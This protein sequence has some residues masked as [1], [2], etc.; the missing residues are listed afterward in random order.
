MSPIARS[1]S[2]AAVLATLVAA[3]VGVIG[4]DATTLVAAPTRPT[5]A[6]PTVLDRHP[7]GPNGG[8]Q[9]RVLRWSGHTWLVYPN[10]QAGPENVPLSNSTSAVHVD[11]RGRLHLAV[12]HE[13]GTWRSVELESLDPVSYGT[14]SMVVDTATAKFDPYTVLGMFVYRPGSKKLTNEIDIEDSRFPHLLK[15][16]D[17]AQFTVQPYYTQGNQHGYQLRASS[18]HIFQQFTWLPGT[19]GNGIARFQTRLGTTPHSPLIDK[20][21]Y[22]GYA[23]P[24]P[25]NMHLYLIL[26]MNKN[27]PP[28]N[29]THS[30]I[31][32]SYS[33][34]SAY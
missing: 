28:L 13:R 20:W 26:W 25:L 23:V 31:I 32:R 17:N 14:Y 8:S 15:P 3:I 18:Q 29:G 16:P 7:I 19:P 9:L 27:Q 6:P 24:A 34:D 21:A 4:L 10:D 33:F 5:T 1:G 11:S 2:R 22:Q 12:V 30:A